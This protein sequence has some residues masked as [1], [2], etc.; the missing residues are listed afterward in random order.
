[1]HLGVSGC[2]GGFVRVGTFQILCAGIL[3]IFLN[4]F[5]DRNETEK[6]HKY[7]VFTARILCSQCGNRN[8]AYTMR[9]NISA[10]E[11]GILLQPPAQLLLCFYYCCRAATSTEQSWT[12][13]SLLE[14]IPCKPD[15]FF[16]K[17]IIQ[18][19]HL[20]QS[21]VVRSTSSISMSLL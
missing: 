4:H 11:P 7:F 5:H 2:E 21:P 13:I 10:V 12:V 8:R 20:F 19:M 14:G 9:P 6:H 16:N 3:Q 15:Q 18:Q 1:M 17:H